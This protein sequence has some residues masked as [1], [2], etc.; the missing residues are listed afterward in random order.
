MRQLQQ[1]NSF[2]AQRKI[3]KIWDANVYNMVATK[4]I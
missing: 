2:M 3:M 1:K 4:L